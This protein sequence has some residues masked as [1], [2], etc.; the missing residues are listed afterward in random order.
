MSRDPCGYSVG[1]VSDA[2]LGVKCDVARITG[3]NASSVAV[4]GTYPLVGCLSAASLLV[5]QSNANTGGSYQCA[6]LAA[7]RPVYALVYTQSTRDGGRRMQ[8]VTVNS[9]SQLLGA[10]RCA[11][12][13]L[14][15][16]LVIDSVDSWNS[17]SMAP[18]WGFNSWNT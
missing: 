1:N 12:I 11:R 2:L 8:A 13:T 4:S 18:P 7:G 6:A 5:A 9:V 3:V 15:V 14:L 17:S 10:W 16:L